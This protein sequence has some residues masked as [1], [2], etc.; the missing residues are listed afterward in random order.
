MAPERTA[1]WCIMDISSPVSQ[2]RRGCQEELR[3]PWPFSIKSP[4][5]EAVGTEMPC[6]R[7]LCVSCRC[8]G[9]IESGF[10]K[11]P[12][13]IYVQS[14]FFLIM[15]LTFETQGV[16]SCLVQTIWNL[17]EETKILTRRIRSKLDHE[18]QAAAGF[19]WVSKQ[20]WTPS[21]NSD[22]E[23]ISLQAQRQDWSWN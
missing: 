23:Q 10:Q 14:L 18:P 2:S 22:S 9:F 21:G 1:L 7:G 17:F 4:W 15:E 20:C 11:V 3:L 13:G 16:K 6:F 19:W 12:S 8:L 5:K